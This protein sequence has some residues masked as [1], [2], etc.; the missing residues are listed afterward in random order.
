MFN[1]SYI[2]HKIDISPLSIVCYSFLLQTS[3]VI[4][5]FH[6]ESQVIAAWGLISSRRVAKP[7][8]PN[9]PYSNHCVFNRTSSASFES[10]FKSLTISCRLKPN[11]PK[12]VINSLPFSHKARP[13]SETPS[14]TVNSSNTKQDAGPLQS[15]G[16]TAL[17]R[18]P[19]IAFR[20]PIKDFWAAR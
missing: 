6:S 15:V 10:L 5:R 13:S 2:K 9:T 18:Y 4:F 11:P 16:E 19:H 17:W 20:A 7:G 12:Y 8:V 14:I 1:T 3:T